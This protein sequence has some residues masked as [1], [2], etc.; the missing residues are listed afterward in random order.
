MPLLNYFRKTFISEAL[1]SHLMMAGLG[2]AGE[3]E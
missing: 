2:F 3:Q 1:P